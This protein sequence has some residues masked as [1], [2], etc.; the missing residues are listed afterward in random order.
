MSQSYVLGG[1]I[2]WLPEIFK[3]PFPLTFPPKAR[4]IAVQTQARQWDVGRVSSVRVWS[5]SHPHISCSTPTKSVHVIVSPLRGHL[6]RLVAACESSYLQE[7][8]IA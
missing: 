8:R 2:F 4:P 1:Y 6:I 5:S 3:N 7:G